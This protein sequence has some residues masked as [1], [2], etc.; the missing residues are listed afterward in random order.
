VHSRWD[1]ADTLKGKRDRAILATFLHRGCKKSGDDG[2]IEHW[3]DDFAPVKQSLNWREG[4][5]FKAFLTHNLRAV[6]FSA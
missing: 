4:A 1:P 6:S 3:V 2:I 5:L